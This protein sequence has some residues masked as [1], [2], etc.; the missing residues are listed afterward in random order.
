M[1]GES[2]RLIVGLGNPGPEYVG[3][4]HNIGAMVVDELAGRSGTAFKTDTMRRAQVAA[5][6][7]G[8]GPGAVPGPRAV[9][10]KPMSFMNLSGGPVAATADYFGV[11]PGDVVVVHDD[12]D[13]PMGAVRLKVGGGEAGH[14]GLRDISRALGTR[15]YVRVRCGIGRPPGRMDAKDWVLRNFSAAQIAT[16]DRQIDKAADAATTLVLEG[17]GSAQL[18]FH[19]EANA[20]R[21][22]ETGGAV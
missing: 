14:N 16:L 21:Q 10:L 13:L 15:N 2:I 9:L 7:I 12:L 11:D 20:E 18:T 8:L 1:A 3:N 19:T 4:R 6:R 22:G 5:V 17:L